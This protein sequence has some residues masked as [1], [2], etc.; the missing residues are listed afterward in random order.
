MDQTSTISLVVAAGSVCGVI[1]GYF[2]YLK[3]VR[4]DSYANGAA[5]GTL[6]AYLSDIKVRIND[7]LIEQRDTNKSI[8]TLA[9]RVTRV[10][11]STKSAHLR[12]N[13]IEERVDKQ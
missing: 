11:E 4:K 3:G 12:I 13:T 8:T 5:R 10:E 9:E 2:G 1:F 7:V 6:E